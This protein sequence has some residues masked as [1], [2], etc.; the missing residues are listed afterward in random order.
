MASKK[1]IIYLLE[2]IAD[3]MEF[4]GENQ[5]KVRAFRNGANVVRQQ[6]DEFENLLLT[7]QLDSLKGIG[8][9]IQ[10]VIYEYNEKNFSSLY[11]EL[12]NSIPDGVIEMMN[13]RGLGPKKV[14]HLYSILGIN[15]SDEL[16]TACLSNKLESIKGFGKNAQENILDELRKIKQNKNFIL[17]HLAEKKAKNIIYNFSKLSSVKKI[18]I[19]G[20]L[21]RG[22]EIISSLEFLVLSTSTGDFEDELIK[23]YSF[24]YVDNY[25][26]IKDAQSQVLIKLFLVHNKTEFV[27]KL[28]ILTGSEIFVQEFSL[29]KENIKTE[30]EI[31]NFNDAPYVIPEM[32]EQE[33]FEV[34]DSLKENSNLELSDFKGL[35]HF[36]STYSDGTSTLKE[37]LAEAKKSGFEYCAICDHSKSAFYANGLSEERIL[38]QNKELKEL[39][40]T[41][42]ITVFQGI[43]SDILSDGH[44]DYPDEFLHTFD[45]I[46][47]S[48]HSNFKMSKDEMTK[49]IIKAVENPFTD[50]LGHPTGRLLLSR[51]SYELDIKK[52]IDACSA[53]KVA[54][55]INANPYRLDLDW[56]MVYYAREKDCFL[57]I[58]PDAHSVDEINYLNYGIKIARKAGV[59]SKEVINC[60]NKK[61]F[62][63][64]LKRK[65]KR[66][67]S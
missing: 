64:F 6:G 52:V 24:K 31:F 11:D 10:S 61:E 36:H 30:E 8:K 28:F 23:I 21:R 16:E 17:L 44:L 20:E 15:N 35:L 18:E 62:V 54:I 60:F 13:I 14:Q 27:K 4:N 46:V 38:L 19:V 51:D 66:N 25:Y 53:N 29:P 57:S 40:A 49:R 58:N 45:F 5:F 12:K 37:M 9:G 34:T 48:V 41:L 26:L 3:L 32:R 67:L 56:R 1:E 33:Y 39:S 63:K 65:V 55:E 43:E 59:N 22:M 7:Q 2:D 42:D 50:L 47:A